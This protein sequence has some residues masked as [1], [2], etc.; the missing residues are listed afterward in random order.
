MKRTVSLLL[1]MLIIISL[2]NITAFAE[3][4]YITVVNENKETV[5]SA[6]IE[7][8]DLSV[9]SRQIIQD[10]LNYA[11]D[12]YN[13]NEIL[14]VTLP[15]GRYLIESGLSIYSN[16]VFELNKSVLYRGESCGVL[17]RNGKNKKQ[18]YGY[19]S[20]ENITVKNGTVDSDRKG[21]SS[22]LKFEHAQNL[23]FENIT[24]KNS[25]NTAHLLTFAACNNVRVCKCEFYNMDL[26]SLTSNCEAIQIDIL[27]QPY[28]LSGHY[29]DGTP[30][31]NVYIENCKFKNVD[32][33]VGTHSG[34]TGHYFD[35]INI[36]NNTFEKI[37]GYAIRTVNYTNSEISNNNIISAACGI[38]IGNMTTAAQVNYFAPMDGYGETPL[39]K[40]NITV[41]SNTVNITDTAYSTSPYGIQVFGLISK[42]F[43]DP[44]GN[45]YSGDY[46]VSKVNISDNTIY[47]S[48]VK[49]NFYGIKIDG[50]FGNHSSEKS[51]FIVK[52]NTIVS[53]CSKVSSYTTY[54]IKI[55]NSDKVACTENS[56][57]DS[58]EK[59]NLN[60]GIYLLNSKNSF[61]SNNTI[62]K[63]TSGGIKLYND[64]GSFSNKNT[65]TPSKGY[66]IYLYNS[67]SVK[68]VNENTIKKSKSNG[69][70]I[71]H[72]T[73]VES[74]N[75]NLIFKSGDN[76]ICV[77]NKS[78][79]KVLKNNTVT[80]PKNNGI[81]F[82]SASSAD[83]INEN[84][85]SAVGNSGIYIYN[86][87][88]IKQLKKNSISD[89]EKSGI[90]FNNSCS[91]DKISKNTITLSKDNAIKLRKKSKAV[92][93]IKNIIYNSNISAIHLTGKAKATEISKNR[94]DS[95]GNCL[96]SISI[97]NY[98]KAEIIDKN[99]INSSNNQN[100]DNPVIGSING[101]YIK[102]KACNIKRICNNK[103]S[104]CS[105]SA[106]FI[107]RAKTKAGIDKNTVKDCNK[108][109]L[110]QK[111]VITDKNKFLR[112][113]I[114]TQ[115]LNKNKKHLG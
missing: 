39:N 107:K 1:T 12:N 102:S 77:S 67:S 48:V 75:G 87:S 93:I 6:E 103:I 56:I 106:I 115:K 13:E 40:L 90:Y 70:Y 43:K 60:Y 14:T 31:K 17:L 8:N 69:I 37:T 78:S 5:Y 33:G 88:K 101:I 18:V 71:N 81:Y 44:D 112:V 105:G 25:L 29:Y 86:K 72:N 55:E 7:T 36:K 63:T 34:I 38:L 26:G 4:K 35:N 73:S 92:S 21:T 104:F 41:K 66:G 95:V 22:L 3:A 51:N 2:C 16:T 111:A 114:L 28:Y 82:T 47:S 23:T 74:L 76:G 94:I 99:K 61:I 80:S 59:S 62:G 42:K 65:V 110:Y 113:N 30:T 96:Y 10:A 45:Y 68:E 109:I 89:T 64:K 91:V 79:I 9:N 57:S 85:L 108:G 83:F 24:I 84:T 53:N 52:N 15:K 11:K 98:S 32:K 100:D 20:F 58:S 46:R 49:K 97:V 27:K 50:C 54:G 19:D